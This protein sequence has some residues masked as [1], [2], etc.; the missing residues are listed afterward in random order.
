MEKR[1]KD[2]LLFSGSGPTSGVKV[3]AASSLVSNPATWIIV[4]SVVFL[5]GI[6]ATIGAVLSTKQSSS[7][8]PVLS[9]ASQIQLHYFNSLTTSVEV[10]F[11]ST[12]LSTTVGIDF[13]RSAD[14]LS[15]FA[16]STWTQYNISSYVSPYLYRAVLDLSVL[17]TPLPS[18]V[19][20]RVSA[21][22]GTGASGAWSSVASFPPHPGVGVAGVTISILGD[23]GTTN[24]SV[25]TMRHMFGE[26]GSL[27]MHL[28]FIYLL[29][30]EMIHRG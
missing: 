18:R 16:S 26:A 29:L 28:F 5:A 1:D 17:G 30:R 4:G 25:D 27:S 13:G 8:P 14:S 9:T 2:P 23:L 21:A 3:V 12:N 22:A 19:F 24:N 7:P 6:A 15:F 20:Y 10:A 11:A